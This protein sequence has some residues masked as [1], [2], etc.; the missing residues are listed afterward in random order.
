MSIGG[1][2]GG[3]GFLQVNKAINQLGEQKASMLTQRGKAI[4]DV[5][6][7]GNETKLGHSKFQQE[8]EK[9]LN[10]GEQKTSM[11]S[12]RGRA[13]TNVSNFGNEVK[14]GKGKFQNLQSRLSQEG[15]SSVSAAMRSAKQAYNKGRAPL[16]KGGVDLSE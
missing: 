14:I 11:L 15:Q 13:I 16:G 8:N 10:T 9:V 1:I 3:N 12:G 6:N 4:T 7:F 2:S 5:S